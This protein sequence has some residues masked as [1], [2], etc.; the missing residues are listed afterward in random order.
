MLHPHIL[1]GAPSRCSI[2]I[3]CL[4]FSRKE[5]RRP[6]ARFTLHAFRLLAK[7]F[8]RSDEKNNETLVKRVPKG[9]FLE[10]LSRVIRIEFLLVICT[11]MEFNETAIV[12]FL[13]HISASVQDVWIWAGCLPSILLVQIFQIGQ[14]VIL[15]VP[16]GWRLRQAVKEVMTSGNK[17]SNVHVVI[18]GLTNTYSYDQKVKPGP[19]PPNLLDKQISLLTSVVMDATSLG[20][21]FGNCKTDVPP[22]SIFKRGDVVTVMF[23][24][25][26]PRNDLMTEG[27]Y[28][29]VEILQSDKNWNQYMMTNT[30]A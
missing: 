20:S 19:Q 7:R 29:L 24:S 6:G 8:I 17:D 23:W 16:G 26:C 9:I 12:F 2:H 3:T 22:G 30:G 4:P 5:E 14:L 11:I 13:G 28:A 1:I 25:A 18:A 15:N 27:T 10:D 21:S